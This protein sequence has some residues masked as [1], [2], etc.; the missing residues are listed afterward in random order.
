MKVISIL[1]VLF[2]ATLAEG[3]EYHI[4]PNTTFA[5]DLNALCPYLI[6]GDRVIFHASSPGGSS[7][8]DFESF[9]GTYT[10]N[11]HPNEPI[12]WTN[13]PGDTIIFTTSNPNYNVIQ[14][15]GSYWVFEGFEI[16]GDSRAQHTLALR[17]MSDTN[18]VVVQNLKVHDLYQNAITANTYGA[19]YTNLTFRGNEIWNTADT[20]ECLYLGCQGSGTTTPCKVIDSLVEFNY[21][22]DTCGGVGGCPPGAGSE[23]S[24][25][26]IKFGSYNNIVRN[27]VC[28]KV[29][30]PCVLLYDD[31]DLGA[32]LVEGNYIL[33]T[34][35]DSAIQVSA[36]VVIRNNIIVGSGRDG[37]TITTSTIIWVPATC[38][39]CTTRSFTMLDTE[40][41]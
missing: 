22:H 34:V 14:L 18:H 41:Q 11:G 7:T 5:R 13:N 27:N 9:G 25:F 35:S 33:N 4:S 24:G 30:K 6:G 20:G 36:G 23:G 8:Y 17:L 28:Y 19:T 1:V 21:C 26:Q 10:F 29:N 3:V 40:S 38:I 2:L 37:I 16:V 39:S 32:N 12:I 15:A 31:W